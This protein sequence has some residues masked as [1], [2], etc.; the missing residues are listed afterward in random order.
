MASPAHTPTPVAAG[1][2]ANVVDLEAAAATHQNYTLELVH[3]HTKLDPSADVI[4]DHKTGHHFHRKPKKPVYSLAGS[5]GA[6]RVDHS[7]YRG[8]PIGL[9]HSMNSGGAS[10]RSLEESQGRRTPAPVDNPT[11]NAQMMDQLRILI[12]EEVRNATKGHAE[13]LREHMN[14]AIDLAKEASKES[15]GEGSDDTK[16]KT[17]SSNGSQNSDLTTEEEEPEFPNAW[18]RIRYKYREP[19][20]E[21]LACFVLLT[22]GDGINV[23]VLASVM[24]DPTSPKGQYLSISF[25]WGVAVMMAVYVAGGISGGHINPGV[26]LALACFRGF[27]WKKVPIYIAAQLAGG[28][29]GALSVYGLYAVPLRMIDPGQTEMTADLFTTYPAT[30]LRGSPALRAVTAYNEIYA[31][32]SESVFSRGRNKQT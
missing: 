19:F 28:V 15:E 24:V 10:R 12:R 17:M 2:L 23:Q 5:K 7:A 1:E 22:F 27:P 21:F 3:S 30:F 31:S 18:S 13:Q 9:A 26:T 20:A 32:A 8:A 11:A 6:S 4:K 16:L 14:D 25:G 29:V